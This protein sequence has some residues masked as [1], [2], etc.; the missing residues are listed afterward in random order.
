[1]S[2]Q[3]W[4]AKTAKAAHSLLKIIFGAGLRKNR[5]TSIKVRSFTYRWGGVKWKGL[6]QVLNKAGYT[7]ISV[8]CG[9]VRTVIQVLLFT[10]KTRTL[11]PD[12]LVQ[13]TEN[14]KPLFTVDPYLTS[15]YWSGGSSFQNRD[16]L[17]CNVQA[18]KNCISV[19]PSFLSKSQQKVQ[20]LGEIWTAVS[21]EFAAWCCSVGPW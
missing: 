16:S 6:L 8:A 18:P 11:Q 5:A 13:H 7:T 20:A 1:M 9:W 4:I 14:Q 10:R 21:Q 3:V 12:R 15:S 17:T 19:C 2:G